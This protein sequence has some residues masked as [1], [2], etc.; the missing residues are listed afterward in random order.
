MIDIRA[1]A[2]LGITGI[3]VQICGLLANTCTKAEISDIYPGGNIVY[4]KDPGVSRVFIT[5]TIDRRYP[6]CIDIPVPWYDSVLIPLHIESH[7]EVEII[8][9]GESVLKTEIEGIPADLVNAFSDGAAAVDIL[10]WKVIALVGPAKPPY[11]GCSIIPYHAV[12][13][14][15]YQVVFGQ[16]GGERYGKCQEFVSKNCEKSVA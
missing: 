4:V 7:K 15:I 16:D 11:F 10:P 12:F 14:A 8:V 9:N 13:P 6:I 1:R 2:F 3:S 5:E